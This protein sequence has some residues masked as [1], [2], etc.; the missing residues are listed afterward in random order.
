M[1][2]HFTVSYVNYYFDNY[3]YKFIYKSFYITRINEN[4]YLLSYYIDN[5]PY[6]TVIEIQKGPMNIISV[7]NNPNE[8]DSDLFSKL[9]SFRTKSIEVTP[10]VLGVEKLFVKFL[11]GDDK[12]FKE[13]D[14]IPLTK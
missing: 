4:Q 8:H 2:V 13:N 9:S 7:S 10:H 6:K 14:I 1:Y 3:L 5:R 11:D 12:E